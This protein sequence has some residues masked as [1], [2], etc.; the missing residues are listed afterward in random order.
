MLETTKKTV[1]IGTSDFKMFFE[2]GLLLCGQNFI[3]KRN[4]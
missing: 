2:K 3:Y 4:S 1:P